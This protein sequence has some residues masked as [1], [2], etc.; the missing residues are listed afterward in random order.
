MHTSR[1]SDAAGLQTQKTLS[2]ALMQKTK[3]EVEG[4]RRENR[5]RRKGGRGKDDWVGREVQQTATIKAPPCN[6]Q[7]QKLKTKKGKK[8]KNHL[9]KFSN[10]FICPRIYVVTAT[11]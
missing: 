8:K 1:S 7:G 5:R 9:F 11:N 10:S 3:G 2:Q 6:M 4:S